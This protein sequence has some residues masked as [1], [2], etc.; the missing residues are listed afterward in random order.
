MSFTI[1][2]DIPFNTASAALGT[3][4][5]VSKLE[6]KLNGNIKDSSDKELMDVCKS[7][8]SYFVEQVFKEMKKTV[9]ENEENNE[10]LDYFGDRLY[11]EYAGEVTES[12]DL[13]I[14]RMLYESMKRNV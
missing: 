2:N 7:F 1:G 5:N 6:A 13:G 9:P 4:D 11:Q 12:G 14:A 3:S 10:Y 8:E